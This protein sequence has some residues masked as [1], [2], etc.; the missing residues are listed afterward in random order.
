MQ[1]TKPKTIFVHSFA[2]NLFLLASLAI[3]PF[4]SFEAVNLPKFTILI[5][6]GSIALVYLIR[7]IKLVFSRVGIFSKIFLVTFVIC[8]SI[9]FFSSETPWVQQLYGRE[10][11]RNGVLTFISLLLVF[12]IYHEISI[13][14]FKKVFLNRIAISGIIISLYSFLQLIGL[15]FFKWDSVNLHFFGTFGNPN[16]L[17]AFL[18][19]VT[20]PILVFTKDLLY[21]LPRYIVYIIQILELTFIAYLIIR[22]RSYQGYIAVCSALL[23]FV[24]IWLYKSKKKIIFSILVFISAMLT[25]FALAGVLNH[26]PLSGYLYKSSI[27]SRGDFFRTAFNAGNANMFSGLGFESFGDYYFTYRDS[28]AGS[29]IGAEYADS[30]HNYFLDIYANFGLIALLLYVGLTILV[31]LRFI[32]IFRSNVFD[33]YTSSIFSV[34]VALQI[35]SLVSP[36]NFLFLIL[37]FAI[38][39]LILGDQILIS[40]HVIANK[41]LTSY[42]VGALIAVALVTSPIQREHLVLIANQNGSV[43]QLIKSLDKFPKSTTGYSR[44]LLLFDENNL[45]NESLLVAKSALEFNERTYTAYVVIITSP[46]TSREEKIKAYEKLKSLDPKNPKL[47]P[48]SP[49]KE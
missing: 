19:M 44:T 2:L 21:K 48:L 3:A 20:M 13:E 5:T 38:S 15:D 1:N 47:A 16:F 28:K 26:G 17:S 7:N 14:K 45:L 34:W 49:F 12:I 43:E 32:K 22:T 9:S 39:G 37:I 11:R 8:L 33:K 10:G 41:Q 4:Y 24:L 6:F 27:A 36:T 35:Q 25:S 29:R 30:A 40:P 46:Y 23:V 18:A 42:V 31:L